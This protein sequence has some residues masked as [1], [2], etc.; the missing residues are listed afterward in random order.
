MT[1]VRQPDQTR[2]T[3]LNAAF[4]EMYDQGFRSASLDNILKRTGVTKGALYHHF[5]NKN[6]LGL[7]VVEEVLFPIARKHWDR[8]D[9]EALNPIDT[10]LE[11][12]RREIENSTSWTVTRGCPFNNLV[13]EMSGVDE[14]FRESL[15]R[16]QS[17]WIEAVKTALVR[18][19]NQGH[20]DAD[21]DP[22]EAA[23]FI[24]AGYEGC[25][26]IAKC[27]SSVELFATCMSGMKQYLESLRA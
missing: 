23:T 21:V 10:I 2:E 3:L 5:P 18:G 11:F 17:Q 25:V 26:G 14:K 12:G 19:K 7:A 4:Q 24:I 16:I 27:G 8:L 20:V 9:D 6:A 1:H 15:S 22:M 13:Q